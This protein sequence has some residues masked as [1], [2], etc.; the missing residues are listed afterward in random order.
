MK[1]IGVIVVLAFLVLMTALAKPLQ[2]NRAFLRP[3]F[4]HLPAWSPPRIAPRSHPVFFR[5]L[6]R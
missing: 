3:A 1:G 6:P 5:H 2:D 4:V